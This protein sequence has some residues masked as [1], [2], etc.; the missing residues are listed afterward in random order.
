MQIY[1]KKSISTKTNDNYW[2]AGEAPTC[3]IFRGNIHKLYKYN[4]LTR[5]GF[6]VPQKHQFICIRR[7]ADAPT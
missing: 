1:I 7:D 6:C 3:Q 2:Y 5:G 4:T